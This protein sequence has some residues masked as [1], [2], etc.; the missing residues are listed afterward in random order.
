MSFAASGEGSST[1]S[2][3]VTRI[4][5]SRTATPAASGDVS[6]NRAA[7]SGGPASRKR[8]TGRP[9]TCARRSCTLPQA[10]RRPY[11]MMPTRLQISANSGRMWLETR[12][13]LPSPCSRFSSPRISILAR[14][15][16]PLAGSSRSST[17]GSC[18]STRARPNRWVMPRERLVTSS[19]RLKAR[20]TSSSDRSATRRRSG[21]SIR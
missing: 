2:A 18:S 12:I 5:P 11:S 20:S 3:R 9:R 8:I 4:S 16:R 1:P 21:P 19:S 7:F 13:V 14:G 15:S 6:S 17:C 10:N